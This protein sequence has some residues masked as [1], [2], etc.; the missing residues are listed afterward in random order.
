MQANPSVPDLGLHDIILPPAPSSWPPSLLALL[1]A[2]V[3]V[4]L[5]VVGVVFFIQYRTKRKVK[6]A[7][8][9]QL[10]QLKATQASITELSALLKQA[11][12]HYYPR[13]QVAS[14]HGAAWLDYLSKSSQQ[15]ANFSDV[16]SRWLAAFY[17][18]S[19][20]ANDADFTLAKNWLIHALPANH[21]TL[22][23]TSSKGS[24]A[25]V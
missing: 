11:A 3:I 17:Q 12:L 18:R 4:I 24:P 16:K 8:I 21:T 23:V 5:I 19:V 15:K 13:E 6:R 1:I 2:L 20:M 14:L 10:M 9:A 25:H 7:A 22:K